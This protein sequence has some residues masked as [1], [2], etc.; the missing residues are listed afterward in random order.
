MPAKLIESG[1]TKTS[2]VP[3]LSERREDDVLRRTEAHVI[4]GTIFMMGDNRDAGSDSRYRGFVPERN[5]VG[6]TF[7]LWSSAARPELEGGMRRS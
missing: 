4:R 1:G 2:V 3:A 5:L 6:R 7:V